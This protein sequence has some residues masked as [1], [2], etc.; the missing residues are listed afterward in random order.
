MV[1]V[2]SEK[3]GVHRK[4]IIS[5]PRYSCTQ[6]ARQRQRE[7]DTKTKEEEENKKRGIT[8]PRKKKK[9][10]KKLAFDV[11]SSIQKSHGTTVSIVVVVVVVVVVV[12]LL[13]LP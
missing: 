11:F 8:K 10:A 4:Q 13:F 3:Q 9:T 6:F 1:R 2:R 5:T 12:F 7:G